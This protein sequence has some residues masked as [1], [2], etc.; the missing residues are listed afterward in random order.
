MGEAK[1]QNNKHPNDKGADPTLSFDKSN[2]RS[3]S[4]I[5][6]YLIK[7]ELGRG[8]SG[9]VYLAH[10]TKLDRPI[11][12]KSISSG[13]LLENPRVWSR[14]SRE[15]RVLASLNHPH[16][17]TIYDEIK[18]ANGVDYIILEYVPGQTLAE[19]INISK[20]K[21]QEVLNIVLQIAEAV[22]TA[23]NHNVIHRDLKPSN[24]K[25]TP[26]GNV[27]VLDFG[28]AKTLNVEVM[29]EQSTITELGRIIGTPTYMSPE[30][31]KGIPVDRRS[32]IW[33]FGCILFEMLADSIP[34][35]GETTSEILANIINQ[36]P[37]WKK[38]PPQI[39][40]ELRKIIR[41][42]LKKEPKDRYQSFAEI[43]K[44]LHVYKSTQT[45]TAISPKI[46]LRA[47][48][49]PR[50]AIPFVF[51]LIT[52]SI[53]VFYFIR[54]NIKEKWVR[55][56]AIPKIKKL[57]EEDKFRAAYSL[58]VEAEKFIPNDPTLKQLWPIMSVNITIETTP[59]GANVYM[60]DYND[61]E[62]KWLYFGKTPIDNKRT[63]SSY[64]RWQI[65][66]E[67]FVTIERAGM[68]LADV[69]LF[70]K[71]SVPDG[72]VP[73][74]GGDYSNIGT[75][76]DFFIDKYEITNKQFKEFVDAGGYQDPNYWPSEFVKDRVVLNWNQ[77]MEEFMD[78]TE[79]PGPAFWELGDYPDGQDYYPVTGISWYE[80]AAYA[81]F[82]N[83]SLPTIY[84]WEK[85]SQADFYQI[86]SYSNFNSKEPGPIGSYQGTS[87]L[88]V[89]DMAGNVREWCFN[90]S[91]NDRFAL[92]GAWDDPS[93]MFTLKIGI[94]PF[95]RSNK[96][97][98][99]CA[100][101][102]D[103]EKVPQ[104][105][106]RSTLAHRDYRLEDPNIP[107][108]VF[109]LY[110][111]RYFYDSTELD[112]NIVMRDDSSEDWIKEIVT[113]NATYGNEKINAYLLLPKKVD[114]PY[115]T[116]IY[117]PG[118]NARNKIPNEDINIEIESIDFLV[119]SGRA[120][121]FPIYKG[122][123]E[124]NEGFT[125][126]FDSNYMSYEYRDFVTKWTQ[127]FMR[128]IDY[129]EKRDDIDTENLAFWGHSWGSSMGIIIC[130]VEKRIKAAVFV[131]GGLEYFIRETLPEVD[132]INYISHVTCP[133]LMI[134]GDH[135]PIRPLELTVYPCFSFLST[136]ANE[137]VLK[138]YDLGHFIP[139][140]VKLKD[141]LNFLD[142]YL[143]KVK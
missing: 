111:S 42:C 129:L 22:S 44:D 58:A 88:G 95:D 62:G 139:R 33:S 71:R 36:E 43:C 39:D 140:D 57:I 98:F 106:F 60:K 76:D 25:I 113:Y 143:G 96:N 2:I 114:P 37:D 53:G 117:F 30:Q 130:A 84:H 100:K 79:R 47:I 45:A 81:K 46:L 74:P 82:R 19:L 20:L 141:G 90:E 75:L 110:K 61:L 108:A 87:S 77:A 109:Q 123:Y 3:G 7:R 107:E 119:K 15:A 91:Q 10:D 67:G 50:I 118:A 137:K 54:E 135:D 55:F 121:I 86:T 80:A 63:W 27:K 124:R 35:K 59:H 31:A 12:I 40:P 26:D 122:T 112:A 65:S 89:Y 134:N 132:K 116:I 101:Y 92:G 69:K 41:K 115:Q 52:L 105:A 34:F 102:Q 21:I 6:H 9:V 142:E 66:K 4:Q 49:K 13:E 8:A 64:K 125:I 11:A 78:S 94:S 23:H 68:N 120:V 97:G 56:E 127:D 5:G 103:I 85:A 99:R 138:I 17:A 133:V 104:K 32:D 14:F 93:Y 51:V 126:N 29:N 18:E 72:M 73:I 16:I 131:L 136:S 38:L 48:R 83:K 28:L 24:I 128:T 1:E 70:D